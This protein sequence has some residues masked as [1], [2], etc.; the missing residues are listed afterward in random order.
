MGTTRKGKAAAGSSHVGTGVSPLEVQELEL[1]RMKT[2]I[3]KKLSALASKRVKRREMYKRREFV[4]VSLTGYT[5]AGKSSL[6][7]AIANVDV[8][9]D[10]SLFTTLS[11]KTSGIKMDDTTVLVSDTVGFI[12][13]LPPKLFDAFKSTLEEA[14][15]TDAVFVVIDVS[16]DNETLSRK[17][18]V[19]LEVLKELGISDNMGILITKRDL[20]EDEAE[21]ETKRKMITE[22]VPDVP[23][24]GI[25]SLTND[26]KGFWDLISKF[27][28]RYE[29]T[30]NIPVE[31]EKLKYQFYGKTHVSN[32]EYVTEEN[33]IRLEIA[34]RRPDW[35]T[36]WI[37]SVEK[38]VRKKLLVIE[39]VN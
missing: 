26:V 17:L 32:E 20:L 31:L 27:F 24:E 8:K 35:F 38:K 19:T 7:N 4:T 3:Q 22:K 16:D 23:V 15:D 11:T 34:S 36:T 14:T 10:A 25:S 33:V 18:T 12:E 37:S 5:S 9:V 2:V 39:N 28:P 13:D 29:Y 21:F 30:V 6:L 1:K